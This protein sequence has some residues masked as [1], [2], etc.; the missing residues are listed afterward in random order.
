MARLETAFQAVQV[1]YFFNAK[2]DVLR[3]NALIYTM[4][5]KA[6]QIFK[7]LSQ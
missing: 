2:G 6:E 7:R 4:D 3:I 5:K 1:R